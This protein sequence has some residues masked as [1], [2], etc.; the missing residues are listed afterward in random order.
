MFLYIN[1]GLGQGPQTFWVK[2]LEVNLLKMLT[3]DGWWVPAYT[4]SSQVY[5]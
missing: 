1:V 4:I 3:M 5:I 2:I